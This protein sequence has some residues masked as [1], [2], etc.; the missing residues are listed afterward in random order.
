MQDGLFAIATMGGAVYAGYRAH[1]QRQSKPVA[2]SKE[3]DVLEL[4]EDDE[5]QDEDEVAPNG[6]SPRAW[7]KPVKR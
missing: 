6:P 7:L 5:A 3:P 4:D 2:E 1:Q